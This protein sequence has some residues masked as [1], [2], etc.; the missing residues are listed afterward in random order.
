MIEVIQADRD[1][2]ADWLSQGGIINERAAKRLRETGTGTHDV[3]AAFAAHR[4]ASIASMLD[5]M[6]EPSEE[7]GFAGLKAD[8]DLHSDHLTANPS[9]WKRPMWQAMLAQFRKEAGI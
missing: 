7:M 5:A 2:A 9:C 4:I 1:A 8:T 6:S 3:V